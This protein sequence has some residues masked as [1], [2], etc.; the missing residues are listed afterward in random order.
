MMSSAYR[1]A[2][3]G[4]A[5]VVVVAAVAALLLGV[6]VPR[7]AGATPYTVTTG[8]MDPA[9]E[10]GSLVIV[11]PVDAELVGVGDVITYQLRSGEP[12]VATHRVV[13]LGTTTAGQRVFVTQGDANRVADERPVR[14]VQVRG[15]LWYEVPWLGHVSNLASGRQRHAAG[16]VVAGVLLAYAGRLVAGEIR[17]RRR[18]VAE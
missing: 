16:T 7:L 15:T 3:R 5:A 12:A 8:S 2:G 13:G 17:A 18:L 4:L 14:A 10:V 1:W 11:R 9:L 6:V